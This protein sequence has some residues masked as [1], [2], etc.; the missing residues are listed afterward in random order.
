MGI[1]YYL[2]WFLNFWIF[3]FFLKWMIL[4]QDKLEGE[5]FNLWTTNSDIQHIENYFKTKFYIT[6]FLR[7]AQQWFRLCRWT[8]WWMKTNSESWCKQEARYDILQNLPFSVVE[9]FEGDMIEKFR[10]MNLLVGQLWKNPWLSIK[11]S[12]IYLIVIIFLLTK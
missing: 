7:I 5:I 9:S 4:I 8:P 1:F 12:L 10:K 6:S 11:V 2:G 3:E